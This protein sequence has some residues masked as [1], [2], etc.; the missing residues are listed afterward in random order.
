MFKFLIK[1]C[2]LYVFLSFFL[3]FL[4]SMSSIL[5]IYFIRIALNVSLHEESLKKLLLFVVVQGGV[6]I[7]VTVLNS[8]YHGKIAPISQQRFQEKMYSELF[9]KASRIS[10]EKYNSPDFYNSFVLAMNNSDSRA[11]SVLNTFSSLI[12]SF[13]TIVGISAIITSIDNTIF[14]FVFFNVLLSLLCSA[15][16][17]KVS[18]NLNMDLT[19]PQRGLSYI[20]RIH[21]LPDYANELRLTHITE[22]LSKMHHTLNNTIVSKFLRYSSRK[23][24]LSLFQNVLQI[25]Y[26]SSIMIYLAL[27]LFFNRIVAGDFAA[28]INSANQLSSSLKDLFRIVPALYEHSLYSE[29]FKKFMEYEEKKHYGDMPLLNFQDLRLKNV[30]FNYDNSNT[31]TIQNIN[32]HVKKGDKIA[33]VGANGA[34]KSTLAKL[35]VGLYEPQKGALLFNGTPLTSFS[36]DSFRAKVGIIFQD[37]RIYSI[38]IIENILMRPVYHQSEDEQLVIDALKKVGL[39]NKIS[40]L[41]EGIYTTITR[42]LNPNGIVLS[43]GELQRIAIARAFVVKYELLILD[44]PSSSLDTISE[45]DI[46][47]L[48]LKEYAEKTV[49]IISHRLSNIQHMD[50]IYYI[51]NGTIVETGTHSE[52]MKKEGLYFKLYNAK[53]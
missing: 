42:E 34:G 17:S 4:S 23:I 21:Y 22:S 41:P 48:I 46:F 25:F 2:K 19:Y 5:S 52:L 36:W 30:F 12:S 35:I 26:S 49:I 53:L 43:K 38:P 15:V 45:A 9:K 24:Q 20:K 51:S 7:V 18:Y 29:N 13:F 39:Y 31:Q 44:E 1:Y 11:L 47:R 50:Q 40:Q 16:H 8:F 28:L 14:I 6:M 33:L 10:V 3:A 27:Q 32:L 37:F